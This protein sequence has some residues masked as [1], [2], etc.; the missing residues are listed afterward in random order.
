V[1]PPRFANWS[2]DLLIAGRG[3]SV[4]FLSEGECAF[5]RRT[6]LN[7]G[8]FPGP[9]LGSVSGPELLSIQWI[10]TVEEGPSVVEVPC[11]SVGRA[12]LV[13]PYPSPW[14]K[15]DSRGPL[16]RAGLPSLGERRPKGGSAFVA[17]WKACGGFSA[18]G[19]WAGGRQQFSPTQPLQIRSCSASQGDCLQ[20]LA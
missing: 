13:R 15:W 5:I 7:L 20:C 16:I 10:L 17:V 4:V 8:K 6:L 18:S 19:A 1:D 14:G 12:V 9:Y 3:L 11:R 2:T